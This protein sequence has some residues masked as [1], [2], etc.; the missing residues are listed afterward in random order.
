MKN[1]NSNKIVIII[2][3]ILVLGLGGYFVYDNV[4]KGN[5]QKNDN[6]ENENSKDDTAK[7]DV[8]MKD[9]IVYVNGNKVD[10]YTLFNKRNSYR[11]NYNN[12][13][14]FYAHRDGGTDA[15]LEYEIIDDIVFIDYSPANTLGMELMFADKNGKINYDASEKAG[16]GGIQFYNVEGK[17]IILEHGRY[18]LLES[19]VCDKVALGLGNE[20]AITYDKIR[21]LGNNEF[22]IEKKYKELTYNEVVSDTN[23]FHFV[24]E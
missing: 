13:T 23:K 12:E 19:T 14:E 17:D 11:I 6:V 3:G 2:I 10:M 21:Y 1:A 5:S 9:N 20:I 22:D 7:M 16:F 8:T 4:I 18:S 15:T 24:C